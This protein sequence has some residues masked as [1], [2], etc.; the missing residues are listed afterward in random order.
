[1]PLSFFVSENDLERLLERFEEEEDE[2]NDS[3]SIKSDPLIDEDWIFD[4]DFEI[5]E[6]EEEVVRTDSTLIDS[7]ALLDSE[8]VLDLDEEDLSEWMDSTLIES[9][10]DVL[11]DPE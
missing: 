5:V 11:L 4:L 1:M 3:A 6:E 10:S 7:D 9:D 2:W 8:Y